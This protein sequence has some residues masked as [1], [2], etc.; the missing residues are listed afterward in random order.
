MIELWIGIESAFVMMCLSLL[1][2]V[3]ASV[4]GSDVDFRSFSSAMMTRP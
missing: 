1:C 3:D 4:G 2:L